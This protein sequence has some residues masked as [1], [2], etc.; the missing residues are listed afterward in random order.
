MK[1]NWKEISSNARVIANTLVCSIFLIVGILASFSLRGDLK[2]TAQ[3]NEI[4][5]SIVLVYVLAVMFT[6]IYK[7]NN[8]KG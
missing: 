7:S 6:A 1:L 4:I 2:F 3:F 5:G 8:R